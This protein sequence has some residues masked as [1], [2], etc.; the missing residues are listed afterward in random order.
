MTTTADRFLTDVKTLALDLVQA[1]GLTYG[2]SGPAA[3]DLALQRWMDYRLRHI[4]PTPR[5][6]Q[7]SL[8][9]PVQNLPREVNN[10]LSALEARFE[11]GENV[12]PYLSKTTI[13]NDVSSQKKQWRTD[14]LWAEWRIHHLHLTD[15]P[16]APGDRFSKR[17]GWLL[18][19]MVYD[20]AVALI[21]VR[22]HNETDLWTQDDLLKTFIDSWPEQ[23]EPFRISGMRVTPRLTAPGDVKLLRNAGITAPVEH[24]G[25]YYFGPGGGVTSAVT[26][27]A[28]SLACIEV[29]RNTRQLAKWLDLP[30]QPLRLELA[31]LGV[32]DPQFALEVSDSG[33]AISE[34]ALVERLWT[35]PEFNEKGKLTIFGVVKDRLLPNWAVPTLMAHLRSQ[36]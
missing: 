14:G 17:A 26:S 1:F 7:K 29:H 10:A 4:T 18:F 27:S 28:A 25:E 22:S 2:A 23:A 16:L 31:E 34:L 13:G 19:A 15:E 35:F 12:N 3:D 9:F 32:Q 21:D 5:K 6:V 8:S 20:D 30:N 24:N 11:N 33:L 36:P